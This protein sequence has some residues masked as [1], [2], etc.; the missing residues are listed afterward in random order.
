MNQFFS[1]FFKW[2]QPVAFALGLIFLSG[3]YQGP[4]EIR[5]VTEPSE[6]ALFMNGKEMGRTPFTIHK[7]SYGKYFFQLKK[8]GYLTEERI[9]D[10]TAQSPSEMVISLQRMC[11]LILFESIPVGADLKLD[12]IYKGKTPLLAADIPVGKYK[13][14]F[15]ME[16]YDTREMELVV[17]GRTPQLCKMNMRSNLAV[18]H[19]QSKP[20]GA[21]VMLDG[22]YK[23]QTPWSI[24]DLVMGDHTLKLIKDGYRDY[25]DQIKV[26]QTGVF[27]VIVELEEWLGILEVTSMPADAR[28][29]IG[30]E[31]KGRTP[32]QIKGL[33]DGKYIVTIEKP[34]YEKM[35]QTVEIKR[36]KENKLDFVLQKNTGALQLSIVPGEAI[37]TVDSEKKGV[38][39]DTPFTIDLL[40][41]TYDIEISK[42]GYRSQS[43][44]TEIKLGKTSKQDVVLK[45]L[46]T[47]DA[48]ILLKNGTAIEGMI[49]K[50]Q[51]DSITI[52]VA[53]SI[54]EKY[55]ATDIQS[56][57]P[58]TS[59]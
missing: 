39:D 32:L 31:F 40:P 28:V 41:G 57:T 21:A 15:S 53:P 11:G 27:P 17:A 13:V 23:G 44:K 7:P 2:I 22:I 36:L 50:K 47:R 52:E 49:I 43:L 16:G 51:D 46:W 42:V 6:A 4:S 19:V 54:F 1:M 3:C 26:E 14:I 29:M 5:F 10:I 58:I 34:S 35:A 9:V 33:K 20:S 55:P 56:I 25:Q 18:L 38:S 48:R 45:R 12:G 59:E 8:E 24:E 30:E 37:I